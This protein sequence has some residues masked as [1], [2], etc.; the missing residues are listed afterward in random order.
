MSGR[1]G[2]RVF[3][4]LD[5]NVSRANLTKVLKVMSDKFW[6]FNDSK[7]AEV[8]VSITNKWSKE[9]VMEWLEMDE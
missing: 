4:S 6:E 5:T 1:R 8:L 3:L 2:G 9:V 7:E